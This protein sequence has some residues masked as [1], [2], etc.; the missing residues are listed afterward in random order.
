VQLVLHALAVLRLAE[1]LAQ[2]QH[3]ADDA[4]QQRGTGG[5]GGAFQSGFKD[6]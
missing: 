6:P 5:G 2:A 1:V 3:G 4:L